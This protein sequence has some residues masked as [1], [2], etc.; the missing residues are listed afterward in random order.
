MFN[1]IQSRG[2]RWRPA[3]PP[4]LLPSIALL[5]MLFVVGIIKQYGLTPIE[6]MMGLAVLTIVLVLRQDE[7]ATIFVLITQVYVDWYIGYRIV[8]LG[9]AAFLLCVF[10]LT[11]S[12]QRPWGEP[13]CLW[14]WALFLGLTLFPTLR[15]ALNT[16]DFLLY[17]P[18]II[19][20]AFLMFWLGTVMA[21][22]IARLRRLFQALAFFGALMALHTI[23]QAT[24]GKILFA[25]ARVEAYNAGAS[26]FQLGVDLSV[27][28]AQSF[29]IDPNWN[30]TFLVIMIFLPIGLLMNSRSPVAKLIYIGEILLL[31]PALLFTYSASAWGS[32]LVGTVVFTLFAG[33]MRTRMIIILFIACVAVVM[34]IVFA[35]QVNLLL[36]HATDPEEIRLRNAVWQTALHVI[37]AYPLTGVGLGHQAY[38]ETAARFRVP[39]QIVPLDHP[40]NSYLE[41]AA[42]GGVPVLFA[43][44]T[45][46]VSVWWRIVR[47]WQRVDVRTRALLGAGLASTLALSFNSWGNQGWTLPPLA[48]LAWLILGAVSSPSL[49]K[50]S[51]CE[52]E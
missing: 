22:D 19:L 52:T 47:N 35:S 43:F 34:L 45:L 40:H 38:L 10:F 41:W 46:L 17:Y 7:V 2:G 11:R 4:F 23:I 1:M 32:I 26:N 6:G 30:G 3:F 39:E 42:M 12:A 15:G 44:L 13:Q 16:H 20:G 24:T 8:S 36:L 18:D 5:S 51:V 9:L 21:R 49:V 31:L 27:N 28:R 14:A 48:G 25:L 37:Q 33:N 50:S 29:L